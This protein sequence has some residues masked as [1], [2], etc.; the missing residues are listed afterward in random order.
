MDLVRSVGTPFGSVFVLSLDRSPKTWFSD[1]VGSQPDPLKNDLNKSQPTFPTTQHQTNLG[2]NPQRQ[3]KQSHR[4]RS[5]H[6]HTE[7]RSCGEWV[8]V[9]YGGV[10]VMVY[11][12]GGGRGS[13]V[14]RWWLMGDGLWVW[15][16]MVVVVYG[17][18]E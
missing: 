2:Q 6:K 18:P 12:G 17:W 14:L 3:Y 7:R 13:Y 11:S 1:R 8:D 4:R 9:I 5:T 16:F 10:V 15:W